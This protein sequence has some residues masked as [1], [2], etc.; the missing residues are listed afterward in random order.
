MKK[1]FF[2]LSLIAIALLSG[3]GSSLLEQGN[4]GNKSLEKETDNTDMSS[5][6]EVEQAEPIILDESSDAVKLGTAFKDP[7]VEGSL[8]YIVEDSKIY[9]DLNQAGIEQDAL[10]APHNLYS[11]QDI[12]EN[13]QEITDYVQENGIIIDTHRLIVLT[14]TIQNKDALGL[15]KKNEFNISDISLYGGNPISRYYIAYFSEARKADM[16]QPFHYTL[17]QGKEIKAKIAY[18]VLKDD[19]DNLVGMTNETQFNIYE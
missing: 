6:E 16:D 1:C 3:C 5:D 19:V 8:F 15:F 7:F 9:Q 10:I 18:L 12:G 13:Y 2:L 17:E 14:I 4:S 11:S